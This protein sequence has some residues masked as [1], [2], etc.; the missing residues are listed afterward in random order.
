MRSS[1]HGASGPPDAP[2]RLELSIASVATPRPGPDDVIVRVE[3]APINPSDLGLLF[4][5]A[6]ISAAEAS[7]PRDRPIITAP[8]PASAMRAVAARTDEPMPAGNEGAGI[9]V[10]SGG[11]EIAQSLMGRTVGIVGG[12]TYSQFQVAPASRVLPMPEGVTPA[13]AASWFVNPLTA[14]GMVETM[15]LEHHGALVHTAAASNLGQ[16]LNR[17]CLADG[18]DL[19]NIVRRR[20]QEEILRGIG[21]RFICNSGDDDFEARLTDALVTTGATLAF[22][23]TGGGRLAGIILTCMERALNRNT[24]EYNRYGSTT[25]KQ[26]YLYGRLDR[27]ETILGTDLGMAWGIGG[28]LLPPFLERLGFEGTA[29]LRER[30]ASEITTTFASR[31]TAEISLAEALDLETLKAYGRQATSKKYLINPNK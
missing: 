26:A 11:S 14:L 31:Y 29:R 5:F 20:G 28:W 22:D 4:G 7:G 19:V 9:V 3:A 25:H 10:A 21:A 2:G 12:A 18:I 24:A 17:V 30:V 27:S 16:M 1:V 8:I 6:D 23:A 15:R 13:E